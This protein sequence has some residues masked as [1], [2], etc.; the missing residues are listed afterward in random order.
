[1]IDEVL[2]HE[3]AALKALAEPT[4][5]RLA[6]LLATAG[7]ACVCGLAKALGEPEY[8]IS[9]HLRVLRTAG[10]VEARREGTWMYYRVAER[11]G[12]FETCILGCLKDCLGG[13]DETRA[14]IAVLET[15]DCGA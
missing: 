9:R 13:A 5:L 12:S 6:V 7:E 4:R 1:M 11:A 3:A 2:G 10:M 15:V 14:A 8:K